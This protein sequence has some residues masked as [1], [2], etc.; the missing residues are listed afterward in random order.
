MVGGGRTPPF[1][2]LLGP[3]WI[4]TRGRAPS[5]VLF[6]SGQ[7]FRSSGGTPCLKRKRPKTWG[8]DQVAEQTRLVRK[9]LPPVREARR[10]KHPDGAPPHSLRPGG[11]QGRW[12]RV[13]LAVQNEAHH[14]AA[15]WRRLGQDVE[16][17]QREARHEIASLVLLKRTSTCGECEV[18][19]ERFIREV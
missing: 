10:G 15:R 1:A 7:L 13:E 3:D 12:A 17:G 8:H 16:V 14:D 11:V 9:R 5:S 6:V 18:V 19:G 4:R 2:A